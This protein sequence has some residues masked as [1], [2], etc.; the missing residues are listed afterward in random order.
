M[1][2]ISSSCS[3]NTSSSS[4]ITA[5]V[6]VTSTH[7]SFHT[8]SHLGPQSA[9]VMCVPSQYVDDQ[10]CPVLSSSTFIRGR[11]VVFTA[12]KIKQLESNT[13]FDQPSDLL[14]FGL[15]GH[16]PISDTMFYPLAH[17]AYS[18]ILSVQFTIIVLSCPFLS[19]LISLALLFM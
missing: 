11:E 7:N 13:A 15:W 6:T 9:I 14:S 3:R 17:V 4:K 12:I 2:I 18:V 1:S 10:S 19:Q 16:F 5:T 8:A